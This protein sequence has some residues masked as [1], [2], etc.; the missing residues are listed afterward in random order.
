I[1]SMHRDARAAI[2]AALREVYDGRYTRVVGTD[3]GKT[4]D[5]SGR[6]GLIA[7]CTPKI[8]QHHS[9]MSAMGDRFVIYRLPEL[10]RRALIRKALGHAGREKQMRRELSEAVR[11]LFE[12][13]TLPTETPPTSEDEINRLE[14]LASF[15]AQA[16]APVER[17]GAN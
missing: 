14:A 1:L 6:V 11:G 17:N 7:A 9:V 8:D 3:G 2:L 4:L 16:R 13:I 10:P 5:W 15:V 12:G